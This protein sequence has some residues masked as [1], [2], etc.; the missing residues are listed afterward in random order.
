MKI[1]HGNLLDMAVAGD[2]DA[3]VHGCN[4]HCTMGAGIAKQIAKRFPLAFDADKL[5][6]Y[7]DLSK[8]GTYS[9]ALIEKK[10]TKFI[11]VN[12]Y[13]QFRYWG[14][15]N[16]DYVA[17]RSVFNKIHKNFNGFRIGYPKIGAGLAGGD[18][19]IISKI[20][21]EELDGQNHTLVIYP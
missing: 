19:E 7:G 3:I 20:I 5:T 1:A 15:R 9:S 18:W 14:I 6:K 11:I 4:C 12:A 8:L 10:K 17:I 13:T 2:F 21:D 16:V